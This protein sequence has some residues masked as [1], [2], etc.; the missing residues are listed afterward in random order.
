MRSEAGADIIMYMINPE[1][2][3]LTRLT[4]DEIPKHIVTWVWN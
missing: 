1:N 2:A 4:Y 3:S